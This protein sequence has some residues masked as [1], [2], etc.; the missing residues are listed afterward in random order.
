M[1]MPPALAA[2]NLQNVLRGMPA[3]YPEN[4]D[5]VINSKIIRNNSRQEA[6]PNYSDNSRKTNNF[7][8]Q[9]LNSMGNRDFRYYH[10]TN[11][12]V[13]VSIV[14]PKQKEQLTHIERLEYRTPM[15]ED[16]DARQVALDIPTKA[17]VDALHATMLKYEMPVVAADAEPATD[18]ANSYT[19]PAQAEEESKNIL[20]DFL[21]LPR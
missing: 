1:E 2:E 3:Q 9:M 12:D 17:S 11:I 16:F 8:Q 14:M 19:A 10:V 20:T 18:I 21:K 13:E 7:G 6:N 5:Y 15:K 4:V